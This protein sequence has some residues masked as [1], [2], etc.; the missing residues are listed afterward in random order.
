LFCSVFSS[1][2]CTDYWI[3][4]GA[5]ALLVAFY[6]KKKKNLTST[7]GT[8]N[9]QSEHKEDPDNHM[10]QQFYLLVYIHHDLSR[11]QVLWLPVQS[12]LSSQ[13]RTRETLGLGSVDFHFGKIIQ[14][15]LF[16]CWVMNNCTNNVM[17]TRLTVLQIA[18][19]ARK[20]MTHQWK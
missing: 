13:Y 17:L 3:L 9:Y 16:N 19:I 5:F 15:F 2:N 8:R 4:F 1:Y 14:Q 20:V 10:C 11:M 6:L 12:L 7:Q 18:K